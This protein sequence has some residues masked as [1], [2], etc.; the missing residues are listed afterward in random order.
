MNAA[1][2]LPVDAAAVAHNVAAITAR[3]AAASGGRPVELVAVT[4]AFSVD[5]IR[6]AMAAGCHSIGENYAQELL[7][8]LA[9]LGEDERPAVHFIGHL[10]TNK[11]R[12]LAPVVTVWET[13]DRESVVDEVAKRAPGARVFVQVNISEEPQKG[14]CRP[15]DAAAL[16]A[17]A[18]ERGLAVEGLMAIGAIGP[19][20]ETRAAFRRLRRLADDLG[21]P[22]ASMGMSDDF[23]IAVEEGA[24][25]VRIGSA[26][27]GPRVHVPDGGLR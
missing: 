20:S 4:K 3:I 15:E 9:E 10:Q 1:P 21:L 17:R 5:A 25:H 14:G 12:Q 26:L 18:R 24:T 2:A 19:A 13:L 22:S 8:K 11:V 7:A 23:E 6:A 27:F 16:V